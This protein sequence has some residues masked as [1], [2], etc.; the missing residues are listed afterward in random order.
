MRELQN[1]DTFWDII[2]YNYSLYE[3]SKPLVQA[4]IDDAKLRRVA[5]WLLCDPQAP[6]PL[7]YDYQEIVT[8]ITQTY[9]LGEE[10]LND[11]MTICSEQVYQELTYGEA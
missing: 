10:E 9:G 4:A 2:D 3:A 1:A 11:A 5:H 6:H 8:H 7:D